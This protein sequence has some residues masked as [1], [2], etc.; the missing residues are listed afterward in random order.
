MVLIEMTSSFI[1]E[2]TK[3]VKEQKK[4]NRKSA[5][6]RADNIFN[7]AT[8]MKNLGPKGKNTLIDLA[9][10]NN[11]YVRLWAASTVAI[12]NKEFATEVL[13]ELAQRPE[14]SYGFDAQMKLDSG[15]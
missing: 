4:G 8:Q 13:T 11:P 12:F 10:H 3:Q 14:E 15:M 2:V 1:E 9:K 7:L 5:D 6:K